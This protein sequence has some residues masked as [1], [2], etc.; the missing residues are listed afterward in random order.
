[1][2]KISNDTSSLE[3]I[4]P[5]IG[6]IGNHWLWSPKEPVKSFP[7]RWVINTFIDPII[8]SKTSRTGKPFRKSNPY[9]LKGCWRTCILVFYITLKPTAGQVVYKLEQRFGRNVSRLAFRRCASYLH[10]LQSS[11]RDIS[12]HIALLSLTFCSS[13]TTCS[14]PTPWSYNYSH[15]GSCLHS[16]W[17]RMN[18]SNLEIVS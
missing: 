1:M 5:V 6:A 16:F 2:K 9:I 4:T 13:W 15:Y 14:V 18:S 10:E 12:I 8:I 11:I 7:L 17:Q 3:W